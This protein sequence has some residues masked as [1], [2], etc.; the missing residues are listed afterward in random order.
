M[1]L[2]ALDDIE[3]AID[4]TRELLWPFQRGRWLRLAVVVFFAG[5]AGGFNPFQFTGSGTPST[6]D[7]PTPPPSTTPDLP[8]LGGPEIAIIA[9]IVA[10]V[11]LLFL[12][13]LFVGSV[14][15]FI[16]VRSL[17]EEHVTIRGY[18]RDHWRQGSRLFGFRLVLTLFTL[19]IVVGV[20]VAV[21][22]PLFLSGNVAALGLLVVAIPVLILVALVSG[23]L[24]GFTTMFVVP[25]MLLEGRGVVTSWRRFWPTVRGQWK[26]YLAYLFMS[27]V[28][29]LAGGILTALVMLVAALVVGIPLAILGLV[30]GFLLSVSHIVGWVLIG[31]AVAL[32]VVAMFVLTLLVAVPVQTFLRYYALLVLGDTNEAFD[33][34][35]ER[36]RALREPE[37]QG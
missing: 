18:W 5:G 31:V 26:Q 7:G 4:A 23:I 36:R 6:P 27:V 29:T 11:L 10:V 33:V 34:I 28:L 13:F 12:G 9:T 24:N 20:L 8:S 21:F 17:R 35:P 25:V 22:A 37:P 3:D 32:F 2:Y 16:F 30:G 14:M 19:G 15:E 1:T